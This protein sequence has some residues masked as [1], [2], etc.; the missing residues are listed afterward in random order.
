MN[1]MF[2]RCNMP[3]SSLKT[4]RTSSLLNCITSIA[5][6]K[7]INVFNFFMLFFHAKEN[8]NNA[9]YSIK[10]LGIVLKVKKRTGAWPLLNDKDFTQVHVERDVK[11]CGMLR[12]KTGDEIKT[13]ICPVCKPPSYATKEIP[14]S[15]TNGGDKKYFLLQMSK[16]NRIRIFLHIKYWGG[17]EQFGEVRFHPSPPW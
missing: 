4:S 7:K 6:W 10:L 16:H 13:S 17:G 1:S 14:E 5:V 12:Q 3:A 8:E 9:H 2:P 15:H 11:N